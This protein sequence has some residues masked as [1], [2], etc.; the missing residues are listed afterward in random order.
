MN[1]EMLL[2]IQTLEREVLELRQQLERLQLQPIVTV[3]P[4]VVWPKPEIQWEPKTT[5]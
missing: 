4:T 5:C 2:R 1:D 3:Q